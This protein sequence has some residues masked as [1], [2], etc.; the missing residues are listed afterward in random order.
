MSRRTRSRNIFWAVEE[1]LENSI[2]I[3]AGTALPHLN[4][5]L[6]GC[7]FSFPDI[8]TI[9]DDLV[10]A[11]TQHASGVA[12][13]MGCLR[14]SHGDRTRFLPPTT[15]DMR[16]SDRRRTIQRGFSHAPGVSLAEGCGNSWV[17]DL[18]LER[19]PD[20]PI[21]CAGIQSGGPRSPKQ[22]HGDCELAIAT[23]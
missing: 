9:A 2:G 14:G 18:V 21:M 4:I 16:L 10:L 22:L 11:A 17:R 13:L 7:L 23:E 1:G 6:S 20:C 5:T 12:W 3:M 8:L 19:L 15:C